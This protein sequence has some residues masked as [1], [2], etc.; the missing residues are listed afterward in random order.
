MLDYTI[1]HYMVKVSFR[2][3]SISFP[4]VEGYFIYDHNIFGQM[5]YVL[6][7]YRNLKG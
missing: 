6:P 2:V 4:V 3:I 7:K 5:L 1:I